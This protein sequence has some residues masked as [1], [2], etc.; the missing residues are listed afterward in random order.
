MEM[1]D[2]TGLVIEEATQENDAIP[3][4]M[5]SFDNHGTQQGCDDATLGLLPEEM[6]VDVPFYGAMVEHVWKATHCYALLH[7]LKRSCGVLDICLHGLSLL[8]ES[9]Y[10]ICDA[11]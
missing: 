1:L 3:P 8:A 6:L 9:G 5:I 11:G 10:G 4:G 2:L 7:H